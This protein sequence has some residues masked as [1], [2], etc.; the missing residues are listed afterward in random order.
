M[1]LR[2]E[3]DRL[4]WL[5]EEQRLQIRD[6]EMDI[7]LGLDK[8]NTQSTPPRDHAARLDAARQLRLQQRSWRSIAQDVGIPEATLRR[9]LALEEVS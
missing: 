5:V 6:L 2:T 9:K 7:T 4:R 8:Q 3:N 1:D